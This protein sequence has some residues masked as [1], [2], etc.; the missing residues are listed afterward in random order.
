[1]WAKDAQLQK[2]RNLFGSLSIVVDDEG[3][4]CKHKMLGSSKGYG[5][6]TYFLW[7]G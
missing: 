5:W 7:G 3:K 2:A 4:V 6:N 1:M